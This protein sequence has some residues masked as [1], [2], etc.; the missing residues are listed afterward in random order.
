MIQAL[1]LQM[2][3]E[4]LAKG[5]IKDCAAISQ[6]VTSSHKV[7]KHGVHVTIGPLGAKRFLQNSPGFSILLLLC[8]IISLSRQDFGDI[9]M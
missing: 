8:T 4:N 3:Y 6:S 5:V 7:K 2:A 1:Q 9:A